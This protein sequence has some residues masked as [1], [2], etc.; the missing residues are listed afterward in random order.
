MGAVV[1]MTG[2]VL[3][4]NRTETAAEQAVQAQF[5]QLW[6]D[7]PDIVRTQIDSTTLSRPSCS[8]LSKN[9]TPIPIRGS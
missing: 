8:T 5:E 9:H 3:G 7:A 4:R 6:H 1:D 2:R